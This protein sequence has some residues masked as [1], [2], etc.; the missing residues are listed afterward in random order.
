M[1]VK[2]DKWT[3]ISYL[4]ILW[5]DYILSGIC[6]ELVHGVTETINYNLVVNQSSPLS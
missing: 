4:F 5:G 6:A 2:V 1:L 3:E